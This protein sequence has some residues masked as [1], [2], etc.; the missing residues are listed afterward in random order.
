[1]KTRVTVLLLS[2]LLISSFSITV[3]A[4]PGRTDS[5]GCHT[6]RTNCA[7][8]GLS[9]GDY[10]CHGGGSGGGSSSGSGSGT[11]G[12]RPSGGSGTYTAPPVTYPSV[13][14]RPAATPRPTV[15]PDPLTVPFP[16]AFNETGEV[17]AVQSPERLTVKYPIRYDKIEGMIYATKTV[18]VAGITAVPPGAPNA[19]LTDAQQAAAAAIRQQITQT[20]RELLV[21]ETVRMLKASTSPEPDNAPE[22]TRYLWWRGERSLNLDMLQYGYGAL[23][24]SVRS[25]YQ[26]QFQA[27][28]QQAQQQKIGVWADTTGTVPNQA[29]SSTAPTS[30]K[31]AECLIKGIVASDGFKFCLYPGTDN[32]TKIPLRPERGER[33]FCSKEDAQKAGW[34]CY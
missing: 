1:M 11:S 8:W 2:V 24:M 7:D 4:H 19:P 23:D 17:V 16:N 25:S 18:R 13:P 31:Q 15:T 28:Q 34:S 10:H 12:S 3:R 20:L 30:D 27:T 5:S 6:C 9:T 33:W 22:I 32:Y 14:A 29:A 21:G 26:T